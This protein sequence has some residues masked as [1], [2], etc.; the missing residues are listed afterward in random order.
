MPDYLGDW[1]STASY[2]TWDFVIRSEGGDYAVVVTYACGGIRAGSRYEVNFS[3]LKFPGTFRDT[4]GIDQPQDYKPHEVGTVHLT[5]G[6]Q[7]LQFRATF[8]TNKQNLPPLAKVE[9]VKRVTK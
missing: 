4:G 5:P 9:L 6:G 8:K 2:A 7:T 3:G 1:S